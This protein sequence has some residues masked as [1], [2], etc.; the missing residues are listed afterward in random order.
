[1]SEDRLGRSRPAGRRFEHSQAPLLRD[2]EGSRHV[3]EGGKA[4]KVVTVGMRENGVC[5]KRG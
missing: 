3:D 2:V 5:L 1:M 4:V